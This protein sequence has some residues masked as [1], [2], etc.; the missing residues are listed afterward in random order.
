M[1]QDTRRDQLL[2]T[3]REVFAE[4]GFGSATIR[5]IADRA[6]ILSG[7]L[8]YHFASK[9]AMLFE[10]L[11]RFLTRASSRYVEAS[12]RGN[13]PSQRLHNLIHVACDIAVND[14]EVSILATEW[15]HVLSTPPFA[16]LD[17][18]MN[19]I[20]SIWIA[21]IKDGQASGVFRQAVDARLTYRLLFGSFLAIGRWYRPGGGLSVKQIAETQTLLFLK[22]FEA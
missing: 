10:I 13:D 9:D 6:G 4:K 1:S 8:Y 7:S 21:A 18:L 11:E 5:D 2:L 15:T 20:Q 17:E 19:E 16:R 3:A 22:G 12:A 14:S